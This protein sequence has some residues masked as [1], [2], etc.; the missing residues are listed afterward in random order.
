MQGAESTEVTRELIWHQIIEDLIGYGDDLNLY[1]ESNGK[2]LK[3]FSEEG[4]E[5]MTR[6]VAPRDP[7]A[8][9]ERFRE[10][11]EQMD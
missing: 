1:G 3:F 6:F 2:W 8:F 11:Q 10:E 5:D 9:W 4:W 7:F